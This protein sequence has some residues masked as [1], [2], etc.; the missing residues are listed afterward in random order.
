MASEAIGG[1]RFEGT[2]PAELGEL[3]RLEELWYVRNQASCALFAISAE[4]FD[5]IRVILVRYATCSYW[6]ARL[7]IHAISGTIPASFGN[8][9]ARNFAV[10]FLSQGYDV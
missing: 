5:P 2:L 10:L 7:N 8:L 1:G 9:G 3:V 4:Y 6:L